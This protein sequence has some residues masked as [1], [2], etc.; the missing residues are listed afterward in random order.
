MNLLI[1]YKEHKY[2]LKLANN[3][4]HITSDNAICQGRTCSCNIRKFGCNLLHFNV[5]ILLS[6][7]FTVLTQITM[8][9]GKHSHFFPSSRGWRTQT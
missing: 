9:G 2:Q 4:R 1:F 3:C 7:I 5:V 6:A 8:L